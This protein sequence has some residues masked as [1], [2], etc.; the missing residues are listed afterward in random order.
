MSEPSI[1]NCKRENSDSAD[2]TIVL[3]LQHAANLANENCDRATVLAQKLSVRLREAESRINQLELELDAD[4]LANRMRTETE[5]VVAQIQSDARARVERAKREAVARIARVEAQAESRVR[6]LQGEFAQAQQLIDRAKA[7]AQFAQ[8]RIM[9][10]QTEA[11]DLRSAQAE[12]E[13]QVIRLTS[14]LEQANLRADHAEQ[15]LVQVRRQIEDH[16][17][18]AFATIHA[19]YTP[20]WPSRAQSD[21]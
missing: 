10:A 5:A 1:P 18:P 17:M 2:P 19:A 6:Q 20:I 4:E 13:D 16:L 15:W 11:N 14:D 9:F 3:Q 21:H 7:D 12:L 8:E